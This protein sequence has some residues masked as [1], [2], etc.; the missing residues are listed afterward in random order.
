[1]TAAPAAESLARIAAAL[2]RLAPPPP[3]AADAA[4]HPAYVWRETTLIGARAF[5]PLALDLLTGIDPQKAA[6]LRNARRLAEKLP[7][8]DV[9]LWSRAWSALCRA[10]AGTSR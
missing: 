6:L 3:V 4:A 8:H 2:E 10:R 9:L 7:A 1:M 5:R